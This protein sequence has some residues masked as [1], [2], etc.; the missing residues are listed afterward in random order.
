MLLYAGAKSVN[1]RLLAVFLVFQGIVV[2]L[3]LVG[4]VALIVLLI[5]SI[6]DDAKVRIIF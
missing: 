3:V 1:P 6:G 5:V 4:A 2:G